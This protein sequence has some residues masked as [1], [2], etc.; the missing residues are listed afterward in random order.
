MSDFIS[1]SEGHLIAEQARYNLIQ[2]IES[3]EDVVI[4]IDYCKHDDE[5]IFLFS[6]DKPQLS[7]NNLLKFISLSKPPMLNNKIINKM[8]VRYI[9]TKLKSKVPIERRSGFAI[10]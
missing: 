1:V 8:G 3:L 5:S 9:R 6:P 7:R 4:H 10:S 2:K